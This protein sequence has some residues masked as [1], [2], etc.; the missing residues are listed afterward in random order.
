MRQIREWKLELWCN[1]NGEC[2]VENWLD[3]LTD[4]QFKSIAKEM[5]LL[6][7]C[8][9]SLK[10]PHSRSLKNG[11]FELRE[12]QYGLRIY[13]TFF[14]DKIILLLAAGNKKTQKKDIDAARHRLDNLTRN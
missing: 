13:Y 6:E 10:L 11:L 1:N 2:T 8:C 9:N 4:D 7:L 12:R 5:K 14:R 3:S